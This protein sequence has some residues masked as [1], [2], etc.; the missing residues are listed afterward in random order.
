MTFDPFLPDGF[1]RDV[2]AVLKQ[3][4]ITITFITADSYAL[5][6]DFYKVLLWDEESMIIGISEDFLNEDLD[7]QIA[8]AVARDVEMYQPENPS[9]VIRKNATV[10][11]GE[12]LKTI[13]NDLLAN[14]EPTDSSLDDVLRRLLEEGQEDQ[15][16]D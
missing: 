2:L 16:K 12:S 14:E 9:E 4:K 7:E 15:N 11:L 10:Y 8:E 3:G 1:D 13:L 6:D 5:G